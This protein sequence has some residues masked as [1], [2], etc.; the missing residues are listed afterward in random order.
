[1]KWRSGRSLAPDEKFGRSK[2]DLSSSCSHLLD[3]L[4]KLDNQPRSRLPLK[5]TSRNERK[6]NEDDWKGEFWSRDQICD[7]EFDEKVSM[8]KSSTI[9]TCRRMPDGIGVLRVSFSSPGIT[10][11]FNIG[12][13]INYVTQFLITLDPIPP[14]GAV[15]FY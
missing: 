3:R 6:D 7:E 12:P 8:K 1:M 4:D 5:F 15:C 11:L 2:T 13:Y 14:Q 10:S 9:L